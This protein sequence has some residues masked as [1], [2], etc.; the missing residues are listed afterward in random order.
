MPEQFRDFFKQFPQFRRP[1]PAAHAARPH[2]MAQGSGFVI[3]ADGY[4]VTNNHVVEDAD[5]VTV[6]LRD[7]T[8]LTAEVIGTDPKTDLALIK[9]KSDKSF[10]T[11]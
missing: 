2:G 10:A 4:A 6:K 9:I 3:S 7:G 1:G 11:S 8:E 5:E